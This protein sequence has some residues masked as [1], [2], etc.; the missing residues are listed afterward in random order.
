MR[1][2]IRR[3][4]VAGTS[5]LSK[6]H[7]LEAMTKD[8]Q[9]KEQ[10]LT[11][12]VAPL[13]V[14]QGC[15]IPDMCAYPSAVFS[16]IVE[17]TIN[18]E[19]DAGAAYRGGFG[20]AITPGGVVVYRESAASTSAAIAFDATPVA[21]ASGVASV[22]AGYT[23]SRI[24]GAGLLVEFIGNDSNNQGMI[25]AAYVTSQDEA[26][27]TGGLSF[28]QNVT[29]LVNAR[30]SFSSALKNGLQCHYVPL[31]PNDFIYRP[32]YNQPY[33]ANSDDLTTNY[34][35]NFR[36]GCFIQVHCNS[37]ASVN[38]RLTVVGHYEGLTATDTLVVGQLGDAPND[39]I[40]L[41]WAINHARAIPLIQSGPVITP[42]RDTTTNAPG[43]AGD[44]VYRTPKRQ[45]RKR[46]PT[47]TPTRG[48]AYP[49]TRAQSLAAYSKRQK[50]M[51]R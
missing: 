44:Y 3:D 48:S 38:V 20:V 34:G 36:P 42:G 46:T 39:I 14:T 13:D 31:D 9:T 5:V 47:M 12:L 45:K 17:T 18:I 25:Q 35:N 6:R 29:G 10:Y 51:R 21:R 28:F 43:D 26:N 32:P 37:N 16:D 7:L 8:K 41:Q 22:K 30:M 11:N 40:A 23:A 50:A 33:G 24:V 15:R 4:G 49:P 27:P 19:Q 1:G 2:S